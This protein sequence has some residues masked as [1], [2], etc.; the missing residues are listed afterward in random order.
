MFLKTRH[1]PYNGFRSS[2]LEVFCEKF[3]KI[4]RK[5]TIVGSS[6]DK[7]A[8]RLKRDSSTGDFFGIA[9]YSRTPFLWNTSSGCF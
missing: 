6:F 9:K 8:V 3:L 4:H 2:C 7:A 1:N 5:T